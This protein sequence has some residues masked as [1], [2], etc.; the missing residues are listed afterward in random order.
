MRIYAFMAGKQQSLRTSAS[1][2]RETL[3]LSVAAFDYPPGAVADM[4]LTRLVVPAR[5]RRM[6]HEQARLEKLEPNTLFI[7]AATEDEIDNLWVQAKIARRAHQA[8]VRK[9]VHAMQRSAGELVRWEDLPPKMQARFHGVRYAPDECWEWRPLKHLQRAQKS[10]AENDSPA[11]AP[12]QD[13]YKTLKGPLPKGVVLR[14]TCDNRLCMN[15]NH[16]EPGTE[17]D[18]VRDMMQRQR[19]Y[20]QVIAR[21]RAKWRDA[22]ALRKKKTV[23]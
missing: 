6:S 14:H 11:E 20:R 19:H 23:K 17:Q 9:R 3:E 1:D 8:A 10:D 12:Y 4:K 13:F 5:G 7:A 2:I 22:Y 16:L 15:P 18:N 21:N